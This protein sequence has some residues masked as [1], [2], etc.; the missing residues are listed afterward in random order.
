MKTTVYD[1]FCGRCRHGGYSPGRGPVC[2]L[3]DDRPDLS[4]GCMMLEEDPQKLQAYA[5]RRESQPRVATG[6]RAW[7]RRSWLDLGW[8]SMVGILVWWVG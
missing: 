7:A 5:R 6:W 2:K 3:T 4:L 8:V 1:H